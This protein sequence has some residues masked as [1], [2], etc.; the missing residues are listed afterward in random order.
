M[1][2][3]VGGWGRERFLGYPGGKRAVT[4]LSEVLKDLEARISLNFPDIS[5]CQTGHYAK[6]F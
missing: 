5:L 4:C 2:R 3:E 1:G 6:I